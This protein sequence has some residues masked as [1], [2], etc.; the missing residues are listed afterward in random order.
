[1]DCQVSLLQVSV[2]SAVEVQLMELETRQAVAV[3]AS[4]VAQME[5]H[6]L[7]AM[8]QQDLHQP[9]PELSMDLVGRVETSQLQIS[10]LEVPAP[11]MEAPAMLAPLR[12]RQTEA[13]VEAAVEMEAWQQMR[14]AHLAR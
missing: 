2:P 8:A 4:P 13:A 7:Q 6:Q 5:M 1:M 10:L 12:R 3:A 9:L 11:Q 14:R